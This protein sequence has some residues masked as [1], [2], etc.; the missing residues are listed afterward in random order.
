VCDVCYRAISWDRCGLI[1]LL[2]V[3]SVVVVL[4]LLFLV[5]SWICTFL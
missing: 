3:M 4:V 5:F 2:G 1:G